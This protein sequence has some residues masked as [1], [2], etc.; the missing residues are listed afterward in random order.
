MAINSKNDAAKALMDVN[1]EH[2]FWVCDGN[3]L[4]NIRDLQG[5]F[6]KMK[7]PVFD[8]HVNC[9]RNDFANWISD[10]IL[11]TKLAKDI[12]KVKEK[13]TLARKIKERVKWLEKKAK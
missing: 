9:E 11:D 8:H 6:P 1:P 5:Y 7:K 10:I 2:Y 13:K 12:S 4:R 3:V